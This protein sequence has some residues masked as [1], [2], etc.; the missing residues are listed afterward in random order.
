[1]IYHNNGYY[2]NHKFLFDVNMC[3]TSADDYMCHWNRLTKQQKHRLICNLSY[4]SLHAIA[5]FFFPR[6]YRW[7]LSS[8]QNYYVSRMSTNMWNI[9]I[10]KN[11]ALPY[12]FIEDI[13]LTGYRYMSFSWFFFSKELGIKLIH[14]TFNS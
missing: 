4:F 6:W 5:C 12:W 10:L 14:V 13:Y 2:N 11:I 8:R 3:I 7:A 9:Y 1:M